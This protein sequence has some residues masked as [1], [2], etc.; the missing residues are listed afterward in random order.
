MTLAAVSCSS[1]R[2]AGVGAASRLRPDDAAAD[3]R[4]RQGLDRRADVD[5]SARRDDGRQ[6]HRADRRRQHRAERTLRADRQARVRAAGDSRSHCPQARQRADRAGDPVRAWQLLDDARHHPGARHDLRRAR[7]GPGRKPEGQRLQ[8]RHPDRR[9]RR[10]PARTRARRHR[11]CRRRGP[12]A[13]R[14][15]TTS[16]STTTAGPPP[17][18]RGTRSACPRRRTKAFTTTTA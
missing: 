8:A 7:R 14:R 9:Q 6:D 15:F 16:R 13:A 18:A 11:S 3:S 4:R 12:A 10:Q 17:M 2:V 1:L 5:G